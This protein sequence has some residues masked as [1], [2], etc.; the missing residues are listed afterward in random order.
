MTNMKCLAAVNVTIRKALDS[1]IDDEFLYYI[2]EE[3][4]QYNGKN[5]IPSLPTSVK[6]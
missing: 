5:K 6:W 2:S 1:T 3:K 4:Y